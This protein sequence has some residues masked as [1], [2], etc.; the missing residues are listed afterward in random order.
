MSKRFLFISLMI[1]CTMLCG[2][3]IA[4]NKTPG[5]LKSSPVDKYQHS[6]FRRISAMTARL[7]DRNHYS[8]VA[9]DKKLS[10]RIFD[11]FFD[12]LDPAH[13][14]F[15]LS[16]VDSFAIYLDNIG[17]QL[18]YGEYQFAF[19]V[20]ELYRKRYAQYRKFTGEML[21]QEIDFTVNE[22]MSLDHEKEK[23]PADEK[24]MKEL[25]R[26][27]IKNELL[28]FRLSE[29]IEKEEAK[30]GKKTS[31]KKV[32]GKT[33]EQRILQRR[34]DVSNSIEKRERVDILGLLLDSM[35]RAYG[36]HSDYQA[37]KISEDF[38]INMSLSLSGIGATLTSEDG[39]IKIVEL[40]PGGPAE[41]SGKLKV[42]DR[43]VSV[44]QENGET[45]DLID[46]PVNQ[47]VQFIRGEKGTKVVLEVLSENSGAAQKVQII[48]D[49]VNLN[50]G[51]AKGEI[52]EV[53][54]T[55]VGVITLPSFYMDFDAA[56]RGDAN[57]R[58]ASSDVQKILDDFREKSVQSIVIDLRS[59]G[60]GSLPDAIVLSG[61][62]MPGGPV[63]QVRSKD[64]VSIER[65][66]SQAI[67][68][69]GPLVILTSKLSAS[70]AE[71][72]TGALA[73]SKRAVVVGDSRTFGKGTVLRVESLDRRYNLWFGEKLPFGS[74]TF[75]MAMFFRPGGSSVQ[76]LG[77]TPD[78][79]LPSLTEEMKVGEI[80]LNNHLPWDSIAPVNDLPVWDN[81]LHEKI[82]VLR[83][84]SEAR[85]AGNPRYQSFIRQIELYRKV[86]D[87]KKISLNEEN[88]YAQYTRE[89]MITEEAERL[90]TAQGEEKKQNGDVVLNEAVNIAADLSCL[91]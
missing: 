90:L 6:D 50:A 34:R 43:I 15:T 23:R 46:M 11:I 64:S 18:Q 24:A 78:I 82:A 27:Q 5:A 7:L 45:T 76:Q 31:D 70:A 35:A 61:L 65:D 72:F 68:W 29:R 89:K 13:M 8:A 28:S 2:V 86:R 75:E 47:A 21:K 38:E 63:V 39:Y 30:K 67:S 56:M 48:R 59:N 12:T 74:V 3:E 22:E 9:M 69:S 20:Y 52:K 32:S 83:K 88:R 40:V 19:S 91:K 81:K 66:P 62:F 85:I 14:F 84:K 55:R 58:R 36:A 10:N 4:S 53:D 57:A 87:R 51:A 77:I 49:K 44:T 42:N 41:L 80:F 16:D 1:F 71:I 25:W 17:Q 26:K 60:G 33:P 73:D 54:D 37:P 79:K